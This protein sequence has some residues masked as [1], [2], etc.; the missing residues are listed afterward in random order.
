MGLECKFYLKGEKGVIQFC[1]AT[2]WHE[3]TD[4]D[5]QPNTYPYDVG[6]HSPIPLYEDQKP[7]KSKCCFYDPCYYDGSSMYARDVFKRLVNEGHDGVW[8]ELELAY[9]RWFEVKE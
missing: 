1:I 8:K 4:H 2:G 6:Y 3:N 9:H 7:M 5:M